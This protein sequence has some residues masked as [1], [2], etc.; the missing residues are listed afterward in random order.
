MPFTEEE[1]R[2]VFVTASMYDL[3]DKDNYGGYYE[4]WVASGIRDPRDYFAKEALNYLYE[5]MN[6]ALPLRDNAINPLK[7]GRRRRKY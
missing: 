3:I 1:F 6:D 4:D 2:A 7:G 5:M